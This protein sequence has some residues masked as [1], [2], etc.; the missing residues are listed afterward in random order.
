M[1]ATLIVVAASVAGLTLAAPTLAASAAGRSESAAVAPRAGDARI[2]VQSARQDGTRL[3][4]RG[5]AAAIGQEVTIPGTPFRA[6]ADARRQFAFDVAHREDDCRVTLATSTGTLDALIGDCAPGP[7]P[8]GRWSDARSYL[9]GDL[10]L[11]SSSLYRALRSNRNKRPNASPADWQV[12]AAQGLPGPQGPGGIVGPPGPQGRAGNAGPAGEAG[13]P[14]FAGAQGAT[15]AKGPPGPQGDKGPPGLQPRGPW[16][17]SRSYILSDLVQF[18][19]STFRARRANQS[20]R[21]DTSGADWELFAARGAPGDV[22]PRGPKGAD[23]QR[24][25]P[26]PVGAAGPAGTQQGLQGDRG[27]PGAD[28]TTRGQTG[29]T[30]PDGDTVFKGAVA[31]DRKV[32]DIEDDYEVEDSGTRCVL[33]CPGGQT[34]VFGLYRIY[35]KQF[36]SLPPVLL[37]ETPLQ[38]VLVYLFDDDVDQYTPWSGIE[39]Y[40]RFEYS[41]PEDPGSDF[42]EQYGIELRL[43][44][45]PQRATPDFVDPPVRD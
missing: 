9:Q 32:C 10:V 29:D 24:G 21:P 12:F 41:S 35:E 31:L 34:G 23:G 6:R 19:G 30:G 11:F 16:S 1:Q 38:P 27:P 26:G 2:S 18:E 8:R 39:K 28:S 45:A 42:I 5:T 36:L 22:G 43:F 20:R 37:E 4:I 40:P 33:V 7:Q 13:P 15:G 14:G 25:P 3:R 17:A 44:C